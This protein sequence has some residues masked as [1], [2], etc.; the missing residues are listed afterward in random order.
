MSEPAAPFTGNPNATLGRI[1][2]GIRE[3]QRQGVIAGP[4]DDAPNPDEP[5]H[6]EYHRRQRAEFA[7]ERW[8]TA[9][10]P[11]YKKADAMHP[12]IQKWADQV[13]ADPT[14][15]GSLLLTGTTGTGKTHQAYGALR[16][17]A[18]AGPTTYEIR[19]LTAADMY[20]L[21]R[22][23][24]SERGAEEELR[25]LT[26][27]PLLLLDDLGSAKATEWTEEVTYRLVNERYNACRP[28]VYTSNFPAR[29]ELDEHGR[30]LGPDLIHI[31]GDRIVSRLA[32]DTTVVDMSGPDL[33][34]RT[35]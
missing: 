2:A 32:E 25:R 29:A 22:P 26:R 30:P 1:L 9:T 23:K 34:R 27:V 6:P 3:K 11:R 7:L 20:G 21:L 5:G 16:R 28:S 12:V 24:G 31:L 33:R 35:A 10:P 8:D 4:V 18:A 13:A 19:A 17:I 15:A 14:A